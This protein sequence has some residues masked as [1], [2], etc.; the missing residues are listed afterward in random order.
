MNKDE[1][2]K[3]LQSQNDQLL[4]K[5]DHMQAQLDK[6]LRQLYGRKSEQKPKNKDD[7]K[8]DDNKPNS[9]SSGKTTNNNKPNIK[10]NDKPKRNKLPDHLARDRVYYD[11][12]ENEKH[13]TDCGQ[14]K[15]CIDEEVTEQLEFIPASLFVREHV[16]YTYKCQCCITTVPMPAQ[17][18]DKG[19]PGPGL[20]ADVIMS[21][22]E[23]STPLY[24]QNQRF[25]RQNN[26][27]IPESTLCDWVAKAAFWLEPIVAGMKS[28]LLKS[29]KIH[30]DDTTVPVLAKG[31]TKLGRLWVYLAD[32]AGDDGRHI[33]VQDTDAKNAEIK[34]II[35]TNKCTIYEYTP[36]RAGFWALNFLSGF[37][38]FLQAD[39]Y[40]G[41][42]PVFQ[43]E[44]VIEVACMAHARRYFFD[45]AKAAK[46]QSLAHDAV[47]QIGLLY[48]IERSCK[49]MPAYQRYRY[50]KKHSKPILKRIYRWLK[51]QVNILI[52]NTP[53]IK[54]VN[55][56]LNHWRALCNYLSNGYLD[57]DN[58]KGE[59]AMRRVAIGRKNWMFVGSD[60]GG[61][62]AAI[63]YSVLETC[64][65][66]SINP[67]EYLR[68]V[69]IRLPNTKQSDI[70]SLL[71][72]NWR[73]V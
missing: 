33:K 28:D 72:Y 64:K 66:N 16:R 18:I 25:M 47:D 19:I 36:S 12:P 40:A 44:K 57:I 37:K 23:D 51:I 11:L 69:F 60:E 73:P 27:D 8:K 32:G 59:R 48:E 62:R 1:M 67:F 30:S 14:K 5:I 26:V 46:G 54:A 21:K 6:L 63:I 61:K 7:D 13:C 58:N 42:D 15:Q 20:I 38:G 2:I 17:P 45:V 22:Y 24:R 31:K 10:P 55:Y 56:M 50:R 65:Q 49:D 9:G 29:I 68:D 35:N 52:P 4:K 3:W 70:K 43:T 39:A 34:N 41:Y 53:I 71:P